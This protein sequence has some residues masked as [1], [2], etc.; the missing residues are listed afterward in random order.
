M[1]QKKIAPLPFKA[2]AVL[3]CLLLISGSIYYYQRTQYLKGRNV[4][5]PIGQVLGV[6]TANTDLTI[7]YGQ[8]TTKGNQQVFGG[9]HGPSPSNTAAW[10][11]LKDMGVTVIRRDI[12]LQFETPT[13]MT[14][15]SYLGSL[16][17]TDNMDLFSSQRSDETHAV[18]KVARERGMKTMAVTAFMPTWLSM[19]GKNNG[20]PKNWQV[21]E[22]LVKKIYKS[23]RAYLDYI[24]ISNEP[25]LGTFLEPPAGM[26]R[27]EAYLQL[28]LH[29]AKAI[30]EVD[31][32]ANDGKQI[33]IGG[34]ITSYPLQ[35]SYLE[36]LLKHAEAK[37][38]LSFVSY[39]SYGHTE[40]TSAKTKEVLKKYGK[41][42]LPIFITEWNQNSN[43]TQNNP[44][45][46]TD[47]AITYTGNKL[48]QF[49]NQGYGGANY[50]TMT[51]SD[52]HRP[53]TVF[54]VFGIFEMKNN[55]LKPFPQTK[56][57]TVL[58]KKS[59]LGRG[60]SS[61]YKTMYNTDTNLQ[62]VG[63]KNT[64]GKYGFAIS[65]P[66]D[67]A[68]SVKTSLNNIDQVSKTKMT[69]YEASSGWD[70]NQSKGTLVTN[71]ADQNQVQIFVAP[72]SLVSVVLE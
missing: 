9:A 13:S 20:L 39:H 51:V 69:A 2:H 66:T 26:S 10:D 8:Q 57:W 34:G 21:Y 4:L 65:N 24:E 47:L 67:T 49:L 68:Y 63:F 30:R 5:Y 12:N 48:I 22:D 19:N 6:Q 37:E 11:M 1:F 7:D 3:A 36:S 70:A 42:N 29:T 72:K 32:A 15:D 56:T 61:I 35:P 33:K 44:Y 58:S 53:N 50:F 31:T 41:E 17:K 16:L 55:T 60:E 59:L 27:Q 25:D 54:S 14:V 18:F 46:N 23:H 64:A 62:V 43:T 71:L 45:N 28:F 38:Y 40:P 52:P